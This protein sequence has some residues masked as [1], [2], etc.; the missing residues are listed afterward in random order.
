MQSKI[1]ANRQYIRVY[2]RFVALPRRHQ[3]AQAKTSQS[4]YEPATP[5]KARGNWS[6]I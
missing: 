4:G 6:A 2:S 1:V 3:S 5:A